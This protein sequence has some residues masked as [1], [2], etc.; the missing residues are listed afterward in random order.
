MK[1][2]TCTVC[3]YTYDPAIGDP[4]G[5]VKP[6]TAFENLPADWVCPVCGAAKD[7]FEPEE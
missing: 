6:G 3:G 1:K 5:N 4:D 7:A 2:Y